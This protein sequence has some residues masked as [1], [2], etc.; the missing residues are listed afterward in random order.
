MK[1]DLTLVNVLLPKSS[2]TVVP[3]TNHLKVLRSDS[4]HIETRAMGRFTQRDWATWDLEHPYVPKETDTSGLH[5]KEY[6][7]N[8]NTGEGA[9][10]TKEEAQAK[11]KK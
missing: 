8:K 4:G 6:P 7:V 1:C 5:D 11:A 2:L 3:S 10:M 9:P